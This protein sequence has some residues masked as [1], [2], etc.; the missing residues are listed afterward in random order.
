MFS[1]SVK[2][3]SLVSGRKTRANVPPKM[4]VSAC[5]QFNVKCQISKCPKHLFKDDL[6]P[7][8]ARH[9]NCIHDREENLQL[10]EGCNIP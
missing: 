2:V 6:Y 8:K 10:Q 3:L 9:A 1:S 5:I 4:A 7:I